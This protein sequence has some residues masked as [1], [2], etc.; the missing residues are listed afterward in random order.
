[1]NIK[2]V[3]LLLAM[4]STLTLVGCG[5]GGGGGSSTPDPDPV[6]TDADSDGVEDADDN[7][8]N[9]ANT[10]QADSDLDGAGDACDPIATDYTFVNADDESTVLYTGQTAR[11]IL[12]SDLVDAM[13][14]LDR[15][16]A[17]VPANIEEDLAFF[18]SFDDDV[19]DASYT[20]TFDLSGG[21]QIKASDDDTGSAT[22]A[23]GDVSSGKNLVGKIAGTD[24]QKDSQSIGDGT[25]I[26]DAFFGWGDIA[27]P[28]DLVLEYFSLL[29]AEAAETSD[30]IA[31]AGGTANIGTPTVTAEGL[32][33]RQLVQKFLLGAV[34]FSQGA[35]DYLTIDFNSE[36]NLTLA[37]GRTYTEGAHDFDEAFGYFGAARN[38][39]DLTDAQI[40]NGYDA[41]SFE[42]GTSDGLLDIRSE[43]NFGNSTNC[44]KRDQGTAD[45]TNPTDFT[46]E[47]FDAFLLGREILQNA[48][49][50]A[51]ESAPGVGMTDE[52]EA[53]L[54]AQITIATQTWEK[55]VS[56]TV[57]HYINDV[58]GDMGD[59]SGDDFADLDNFL[60]LAKHWGEMKGFA[61]GLQF[62]P[63]SPF[64]TGE[65]MVNGEAQTVNVVLSDLMDVLTLMGDAPVL[66]DGTMNGTLYNGEA[67][68]TSAKAAYLEDLMEARD[69][70]QTAY[71]FD[72][73]NVAGW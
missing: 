60:D 71:G 43:F 4:S 42:F 52:Q 15:D 56:A 32:D 66:A 45:N 27:T 26:D 18:Y 47:V 33:L 12:I 8:V 73:E 67:D 30:S 7:C 3:T 65:V 41:A 40:R 55:C 36:G 72:P 20:A 46:T 62:S 59:F 5:G 70:L 23:P 63:Y 50:D 9:D 51:T 28:H 39:G 38:Y 69:I 13:N 57:V 6:V 34:T 49:A 64:R 68:A 17:N 37:S 44:A 58:V 31:V 1:M 16:A 35:G 25:L 10:N 14:G 11:H 54:E 22:V 21:E 61:L 2:E 24:A 53:A 48:A 19:R 29:G